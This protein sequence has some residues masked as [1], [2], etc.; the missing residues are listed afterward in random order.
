MEYSPLSNFIFLTT[1]FGIVNASFNLN[2]SGPDWDYVAKD[3]AN[4]TSQACIAAY[5]ADI[6]CDDTLLGLV[7][8]MRP[9]FKPTSTDFDNTCTTTCYGSVDAYLKGIQEACTADGDAAQQ[10]VGGTPSEALVPV[11]IVAQVFQYTLAKDCTKLKNGT[12]CHDAASSSSASKFSCDDECAVQEYQTAHDYPGSAYQF[13]YY[14]LVSIG[15]WWE[16][17]F[18][19]GWKRLQQCGEAVESTTLSS[20]TA[21][22][23]ST[24]SISSS[25]TNTTVSASSTDTGTSISS[26]AVAFAESSSPTGTSVPIKSGALKVG[27]SLGSLF[28]GISYSMFF[29]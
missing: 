7:A 2:T 4:T 28:L 13:N 10:Y 15:E 19:D 8:S 6:D 1:F 26:S 18:A 24:T 27:Y 5:S 11:E 29:M 12:Y 22:T 14:W 20:A 9:A 16:G 25:G 17:E 23:T 21:M 3:L